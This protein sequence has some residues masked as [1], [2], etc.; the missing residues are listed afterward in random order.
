[1]DWSSDVCS[2]DLH[3]FDWLHF[4]NTFATVHALNI[5]ER[6]FDS[7]RYLPF[8]PAPAYRGQLRANINVFG[9][10]ISDSFIMLE[11]RYTW[12]QKRVLL[13]NGT[14][15][16]TPSYSIWNAAAGT[17]I[18]KRNSQD[19]LLSIYLSLDNILDRKSTRL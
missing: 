13:E 15:T 7:T 1:R 19:A 3:P 9:R 18:R 2:S 14:E 10:R 17:S 5:S 12:D 11:F 4:E 16:P 8:I 6:A